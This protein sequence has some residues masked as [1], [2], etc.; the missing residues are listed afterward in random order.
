[1]ILHFG[2]ALDEEVLPLP[3]HSTGGSHYLGPQGL[4]AFLE[5]H[6]GLAGYPR[7]NEYLRIEQYRQVLRRYLSEN[8][9]AFF[10]ASFAA[11]Q[12]ATAANLLQRRDEL[13]LAGWNFEPLPGMPERLECM[14]AL[15]ALLKAPGSQLELSPGFACRF[16]QVIR[17]LPDYGLCPDA[18]YLNE[19]FELLPVHFRRL[20]RLFQD[21]GAPILTLEA[22]PPEG[23][24]DLARLK[25][26]LLQPQGKGARQPL[27]GDG[28]LLLLR[29]KRESGLA[30]Y[31]AQL[32]RHNPD[33]RPAA[34]ISGQSAALGQ[35][36]IHEGLPSLGLLSASLARP[37]L[38]V[39]KLASV[40]LWE[41]VD[42]YKIME[43][44]S[45]AIKPLERELSNRIAAQMAQTPGLGGDAWRV[46]IARY[47]DEM[48][49]RAARDRN[50][51]LKKINYQYNFWFNRRRYDISS[52]A[53]KEDAIEIF[54]YL[55]SWAYD[56]FEEEGAKNNSL[57][58][59][60]EQA[61]RIRE[62]LEALPEEQL[63]S[64][65][66]ER[67]VRTIYEPAPV[68]LGAR[69][70]GFMPHTLQP[71]AIIGPVDNL[72]WWNFIQSEPAHFFSR[73]YQPERRFL[74]AL[75]IRLE[76]PGTENS[77]LLWQRKRPI[78]HTQQRLLLLLP[79]TTGGQ[80]AHPHPLLGD[81]EAAFGSLSPI[82]FHI[83]EAESHPLLGR[84]FQLPAYTTLAHR[85]L[86]RARP[87]LQVR[88]AGKLG[89][90]EE[91]TPTSLETLLYYPYQWVFQH[92]IR[93]RKS[94]ILSIVKEHTLMGNLAHRLFEKL[95]SQDIR[96]WGRSQVEAFIDREAAPLLAREGAV[97]LLY[98]KEPER[99][100]FL[101]RVKFAAWSLARHIRENQ[102]QVKAT[103][104]PLQG[105]F[106]DI[107]INGRADL[108]LERGAEMAVIDLKWRG[109]RYREES[110]RNEEDLQLVL[111]SR[112]LS[113]GQSWAHTAFFIMEKG[114]LLARNKQAFSEAKAV[115][116]AADFAE[117]NQ[118][119]LSRME[120][121][122]LWRMEQIKAGQVEV[123]CEQTRMSLEEAYSGHPLS[124]LLE[125][126]PGDAPFDDYRTLINLIE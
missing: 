81:M 58:V 54:A 31:L 41:P 14:A 115:A 80:E 35:A 47:F 79:E 45:L 91:E 10:G 65:E 82:S 51:D 55:A 113:N 49:E 98:G 110:I 69:E 32:L 67:I 44:V 101:Q 11:D 15:E 3:E 22:R 73:W 76:G 57:L 19:P 29:G 111:Y 100:G 13:L 60:S 33:F 27:R 8:P 46:M 88:S 24:S 124:G 85:R 42:P 126:K 72:V 25:R 120:A 117:A 61:R 112:L 39:L 125:M 50:I 103:E 121:T 102:W 118:R 6:L 78:L 5:S 12:F 70:C 83:D 30:A 2:M 75:G 104:M 99:A 38:Q 90:R 86:G 122:Y 114:L 87:F 106:L 74:E 89:R 66:L 9:Q 17:Q 62:L 108:V 52:V 48:R 37:T 53:P 97:M 84:H 7:D 18:I 109:A 56:C 123:R 1:M 93:L 20:F 23:D 68:Q 16:S 96:D 105:S 4:L 28:S 92:Q 59:L 43:F 34:L 21:R 94:S 40:F 77:R 26:S 95:L 71:D 107:A 64:L 116:S 119:I 63:S 36:L